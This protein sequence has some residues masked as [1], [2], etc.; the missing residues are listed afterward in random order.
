MLI[1]KEERKAFRIQVA[2]WILLFILPPLTTWIVTHKGD[3]AWNVVKDSYPYLLTLALLFFIN[4]YRLVPE[5]LYKDNKRK[6]YGIN[7]AISATM[8]VLMQLISYLKSGQLISRDVI[9]FIFGTLFQFG[10]YWCIIAFA[11]LM[12]ASMQREVMQNQLKEEKQKRV[13]AELTMLKS[14]LNPHFLFNTLNNISSLVQIDADAAQESIGQLSEL[15]RYSLY[16]SNQKLMP[17]EREIEF[18]NNYIDLMILRCN[19]LADIKV[20]IPQLERSVNIAPMLFISLI[21]NAF[22]HGVNS[23]TPSFVHFSLALNDDTLTFTSE[24]SLFPKPD[25]DRIGSGIGIVNTKHRLDRAYS[26]RYEYIHEQ[27]GNTYF[28]QISIKCL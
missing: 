11:I 27:R 9:S 15:L 25:T 17:I 16:D 1:K 28:A 23:R 14:Q 26:G 20:D 6:F 12:R 4:V 7:L 2:V 21:E 8:L 13:E 5:I 24:N 19:E 22:K 18:M 3:I 10:Y